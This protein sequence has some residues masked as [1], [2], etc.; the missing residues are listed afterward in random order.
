MDDLI[1]LAKRLSRYGEILEDRRRMDSTGAWR[2]TTYLYNGAKF[3]VL[4]HDG[5]LVGIW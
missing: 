1:W 5:K 2:S 4:M 3:L